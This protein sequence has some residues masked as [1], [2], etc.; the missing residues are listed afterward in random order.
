MLSKTCFSK[1]FIPNPDAVFQCGQR[2]N[3]GSRGRR[4]P[5]RALLPRQRRLQRC[6]HQVVQLVS[7]LSKFFFW[8]FN[9]VGRTCVQWKLALRGLWS[10]EQGQLPGESNR[11]HWLTMIPSSPYFTILYSSYVD[12][13]V[14]LCGGRSRTVL[15]GD[16]IRFLFWSQNLFMVLSYMLRSNP[17]NSFSFYIDS[18]SDTTWTQRHGP[19]TVSC[20]GWFKLKRK[21][22]KS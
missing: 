13:G 16:C 19:T 15:H 3:G 12:G 7:S 1:Y 9:F 8:Q 4:S 11:L 22:E 10:D 6:R 17:F 2:A 5:S 21:K 14:L 18:S 20:F